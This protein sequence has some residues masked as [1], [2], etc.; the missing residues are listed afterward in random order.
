MYGSLDRCIWIISTSNIIVLA[1]KKPSFVK[2]YV[3]H[4]ALFILMCGNTH[5]MIVLSGWS[6]T[7]S[8]SLGQ[9]NGGANIRK[10]GT[11]PVYKI[12]SHVL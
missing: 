10:L 5:V 9:T 6:I 8:L 1:D 11:S 7:A 12:T 2:I 4:V 3:Q